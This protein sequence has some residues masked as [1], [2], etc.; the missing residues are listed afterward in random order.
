MGLSG[1][2]G[3]T[4]AGL[5]VA[6]LS[7]AASPASSPAPAPPARPPLVLVSIDTLRSDH[8]PAYGYRGVAT[9][10]IDAL[11]ADGILFA[12]AY[13]PIPL[14]TPSHASILTGLPPPGHGVRDN[15]G[16]RLETARLPY[17]PRLLR[18]AGYATG[19]AVSA[20]SLRGS[21]GFADGFD[22]YDDAIPVRPR[23]GL[24]GLQRPGEETLAAL[25]PWLRSVAGRPFFLFL[26]LFEP[27]TPYAPPEPFASRY[28]ASPYD[29]E[30]AA[31]DRVVGELLAELR[32]L[33]VYDGAAVVLLADHGEGLGD[34]GED[35]HGILLYRES[36]QV[37]LIVKLPGSRLAGKAVAAPAGLI[38]VAPTF[39]ALAGL[40][41]PPQMPGVSLVDLASGAA[42][43]RS[44]YAET[45]YARFHFG[46]SELTS[47]IDGRYQFLD[48]P[49]P[50]LY[51]LTADPGE[52]TNLVRRE[53]RVAAGMRQALAARVRPPE[54]PAP[55]DEATRKALAALGY[56]GGTGAEAAG[57][58]PD[59]KSRLGTLGDLKAGLAAYGAGD[60]AAAA[61]A[62]G[63]ATAANPGALDA[64]DY[65]A[66]ALTELGKP[67][68]A[69][70]AYRR[71]IPLAA[72]PSYLAQPAAHLAVEA[73]HPEEGLALLDMALERQPADRRLRLL[74][75]Q[76]LL[77]LG[78]ADEAFARADELV[79]EDPGDADAV[80][81]RGAV[82]I[83]RR[84]LG[85][86]E[87]DL[88]RALEL[89]PDHTAAMSDLAVL[90]AT[91][92]EV[93]E[94]RRLLERILTLRPG[95]PEIERRLAALGER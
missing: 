63:R 36:L 1:K 90:L 3:G 37:P 92:G 65:L 81:L 17:L 53:R 95:D 84:H 23:A 75:A 31:A 45:F 77:R 61:A 35:E 78:R 42:P 76:T 48:G 62:L 47:L 29:G 94:A 85:P 32:R 51:D 54:A 71:A 46:W 6:I 87:A 19:A 24:G 52:R 13:S 16:Y 14:T 15:A 40:P 33:G 88:R 86:A 12:R 74:A 20:Y 69:L 73:G 8:L 10:A 68:E 44:L 57:P 72:D 26:H 64:W 4:A 2:L 43:E 34:H 30:I 70:A 59:P 38:D 58:L 39:L 11:R 49:D 21:A 67:E 9:P 60:F 18:E 25:T 83:G 50:E 27:H 89:A 7:L 82:E 56:A 22:L 80:Y 55:V 79:R 91:R 5:G 28:P 93:A 66:R 41:V